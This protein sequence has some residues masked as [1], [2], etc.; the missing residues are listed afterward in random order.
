MDIK[1]FFITDGKLRA[2]WRTAISFVLWVAIFL[3]IRLFVN[4]QPLIRYLILFAVIFALSSLFVRYI[5]RRPV[6]TIGFMFHSRWIKEYLQGVLLGASAISI[7]FLFNL[8]L[9]Y[10]AIVQHNITPSLLIYIFTYAMVLSICASGFE[11]LAFRG[12][13]FQNFI[14]ATNVF[15]ATAAL[16]VFFGIG[17]LWNAHASWLS[18]SNTI[19]AGV[20]FALAY[21][22]TKSLWLPSGIHFSWN[23]F[24]GRIYS[25]P[26]GGAKAAQTLLDVKQQGPKVLTGGDYGPEAGIPALIVFIIAC[27]IIYYWPKISTTPEMAK[28]WESY[29]QR[30]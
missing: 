24:M 25:L 29:K 21:I 16:S 27:F 15:I 8:S 18:V 4:P 19:A 30:K 12:Y 7:V 10:Y 22:R 13:M 5:D 2:G 3:I 17:H 6:A 9:G 20:L 23:F 28:L 1:G 26:G 11:E 14:E